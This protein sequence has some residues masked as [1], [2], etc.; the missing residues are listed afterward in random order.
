METNGMSELDKQMAELGIL[1]KEIM[2]DQEESESDV[3]E[4]ESE[5]EDDKNKLIFRSQSDVRN[6]L[7]KHG[8]SQYIDFEDDQK[9]KLWEYF[10]SLD[11]D[12]S[13][14]IG[15]E[16]LE[17][18]LIALGL[19]NDRQQVEDIIRKVDDDDTGEI[20]FEE[21]LKIIS[22][23]RR[24]SGGEEIEQFQTKKD[25]E[26]ANNDCIDAIVNC[27]RDLTDGKYKKNDLE[28]PFQLFISDYRR[29]Q[30]LNAMMSKDKNEKKVGEGIMNCF[31]NQLTQSKTRK[32]LSEVELNKIVQELGLFT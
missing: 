9:K 13:E 5:E 7:R 14:S 2:G 4:E 17:D 10:K 25:K 26:V 3:E 12:G 30:L 19:V 27:F 20:E 32:R 6:W 24:R 8:K 16:E 21:F 22:L 29:K 18:P 31:K 11:G 28:I 15:V 1:E 23:G